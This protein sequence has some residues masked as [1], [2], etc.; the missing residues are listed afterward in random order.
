MFLDLVLMFLLYVY[1]YVHM[2][3]IKNICHARIILV[4]LTLTLIF[5]EPHQRM[6]EK[7][8]CLPMPLE[9]NE[10]CDVGWLTSRVVAEKMY[11]IVCS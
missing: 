8:R 1:I 7:M 11:R 6:Q 10:A 5:G 2:I 4:P 9:R 3:Y